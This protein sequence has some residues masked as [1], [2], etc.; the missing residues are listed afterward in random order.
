MSEVKLLVSD[1]SY[2]H[3]QDVVGFTSCETWGKLLNLF[4]P[5]FSYL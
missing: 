4:M 1:I 2:F 5:P 3:M